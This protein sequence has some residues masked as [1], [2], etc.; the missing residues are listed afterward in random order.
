MNG[1]KKEQLSAISHEKGNMLVSASAGS[2][3]TFVVIRR[4]LRLLSEGKATVKD[5]LAVTFTDAAAK[6]MKDK[7]KNALAEKV[8][9]GDLSAEENVSEIS[10]ADICT[11]HSFCAKLLRIYFFKAGVSP[12]FTVI[13]ETEAEV[14]R[15]ESMAEV[16]RAF[17]EKKDEDF[18][19][20]VKRH[21]KNRSNETL[22]NLVADIYDVS[23]EEPD[24]DAFLNRFKTVLSPCG[25]TDA[26]K[27]YNEILQKDIVRFVKIC[28][29]AK[30]VFEK[31]SI[32]KGV[33]FC[34]E[35]AA[36][37]NSVYEKDL[38]AFTKLKDYGLRNTNFGGKN[39]S[40]AAK[41][42]KKAVQSANSDLKKLVKETLLNITDE[43]TD[44]ERFLN[45]YKHAE[46]LAK[47]TVSFRNEYKKAKKEANVLDFS[48]LQRFALTVLNDADALKE[49]KGHYKY[50]F[51]DEYQDINPLQEKILSLLDNG[52]TFM[53]GDEKQSI[54]GFRGCRPEYFADKRKKLRAENSALDLNYNFRS[55]KK[56]IDAVNRIFDYSYT[57]ES[58]GI[59]YKSEARLI[60]GGVYP[61]GADGRFCFHALKKAEKEKIPEKPRI[62]DV[63]KEAGKVKDDEN[64]SSLIADI[65]FKETMETYFDR[66]EKAFV[67]V[68]FKDIAIL[69][70]R[71]EAEHVRNI[72]RGLVSRGIPVESDVT[73][74]VC[75]FPEILTL[76]WFLRLIDCFYDDVPLINTL[77]SPIGGFSE[78]ELFTAAG[79]CETQNFKAKNFCD[80][81][82]YSL[83][84]E[85]CPV[86]EKFRA[87]KEK[88][89]YFRNVADFKGA[90]GV[91]SDASD[92]CGYENLLL[93]RKDGRQKLKRLYK[94]LSLTESGGKTLTVTEF[95]RKIDL[96][97]KAF[98]VSLSGEENA[99]KVLTIHSSK[100]LEFPVVIVCGLEKPFIKKDETPPVILDRDDGILPKFFDDGEKTVGENLARG[101]KKLKLRR[102]R[103]TEELRLFYVAT[104]RAEYS[105]HLVTEGEESER[106]PEFLF[107]D[108]FSDFIP[109][110][111]T[112][113]LSEP[114][115]FVFTEF[116]TEKRDIIISS[117]TDLEKR[118]KETFSYVY[119]FNESL[120]IPLKTSVTSAIKSISQ[121]YYYT[122]VLSA[123]EFTDKNTGII[124]HRIMQHYDFNDLYS[125]EKQIE[126][127]LASNIITPEEKALVNLNRIKA[128]LFGG[129][130]EN[131]KGKDL[132]AEKEFTVNVPACVVY[133]TES[134]EN[135]LLQGVIDLLIVDGDS[136]EILD[137]KY[138][139]LSPE[140]LKE[141]Y[142]K[143]LNLYAFAVNKILGKTVVKTSL[144]NLYRGE[145]VIVKP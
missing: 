62:Y 93:C 36:A 41:T 127:M 85:N 40:D 87:F 4:I 105:L 51:V 22:M 19:T 32:E 16:F 84:A 59:D 79:F 95:L 8:A 89:D 121:D 35:F 140:K 125:F 12:D 118:M 117:D 114:S 124:A 135:V 30:K 82:F 99:V 58:A 113:T 78:E 14:L 116:K 80:I 3:K 133:D 50:V 63:L 56:V 7:L 64:V 44:A 132:Y 115:D 98:S 54:Y 138:S 137:Y 39:A 18:L 109:P 23:E 97:P 15:K 38:Y 68:R 134:R 120:N 128:A 74:N 75:E 86:S 42:A 47:V 110:T 26:V 2:G 141:K 24:P 53:V 129:A 49:I 83:N 126:K 5:I 76:I 6:D 101:L 66:D 48:D 43:K 61:E 17:Y 9:S 13:D 144:I 96:S 20:L 100:G 81:F 10:A 65:I 11:L 21:L 72:V 88:M 37:L 107:A 94:F 122:P 91:L 106:P 108:K 102:K 34:E 123:E 143:Q 71:K 136:A 69:S 57:K 46:A 112:A 28:G 130:F 70:R 131:L 142:A 119:P 29:D 92:S 45:A 111:V 25:F 104:T 139:V 103:I 31:E 67:P 145:T 77:L 33:T 1:L 90:K 73:V 27:E 60:G 52:N 55:A